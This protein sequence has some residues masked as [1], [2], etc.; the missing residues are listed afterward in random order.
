[1]G[2]RK[3][4]GNNYANILMAIGRASTALLLEKDCMGV[5]EHFTYSSIKY[6]IYAERCNSII[7]FHV[8][9]MENDIPLL[10]INGNYVST[11]TA[12]KVAKII[13]DYLN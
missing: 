5:Y 3:R 2:K 10:T 13:L 9:E 11:A 8:S 7:I 12:D 6:V 4:N 1:M